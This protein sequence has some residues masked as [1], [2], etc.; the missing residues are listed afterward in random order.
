MFAASAQVPRPLEVVEGRTHGAL[1]VR[2]R[3]GQRLYGNVGAVGET[4]DVRGDCGFAGRELREVVC[5]TG[6]LVRSGAL[7][8]AR[9]GHGMRESVRGREVSTKL[10]VSHGID[11]CSIL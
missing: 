11:L 3:L 7:A 5:G 10:G 1:S 6:E 4:V 2:E 8:V 9:I